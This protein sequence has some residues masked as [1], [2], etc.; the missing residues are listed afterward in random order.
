MASSRNA[1]TRQYDHDSW[2]WVMVAT[3]FTCCLVLYGN[4][5]A[6]GVLLIPMTND[7]ASDLWLVGWVAVLYDIMHNCMGPVVGALSRLL[8][9]RPMMVFGGLL[10]TLGFMLTSISSNVFAVAV[11]IVGLSG[12][13]T[14]FSTFISL[15]LTASYFK[16]KYPL[17]NGLSTMGGPI[18]MIAYG[19]VTQLLLGTYGWRGTMLLVGG[20]S[21]HLVA[22]AMLVRLDPSS[23]SPDNEQYQEVSVND[24]DENQS[25]GEVRDCTDD[26]TDNS[27]KCCCDPDHRQ[28]RTGM[29]C[30]NIVKAIDMALLTDVRFVLLTCARCTANF[31]YS[32]WVVYMVSHGQFQGLS[33][34]QASFLPTAF[35]VG[36]VIG[37][38]VLPLLQQ[39]GIKPSMTFWACFGAGIVSVS[40]LLDAFIRPFIGQLALTGFVGVGYGVFFQAL[41][42]MVRFLVS[43]HRFVSVLG[44]Q[45]MF[46]GVA[47]TLGGLISGWIYEWTGGF[48]IVLCVFAGV[49]LLSIPFFVTEALYAKRKAL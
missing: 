21:F 40:F 24:G 35:G 49:T 1:T 18:G 27:K 43:D 3:A 33:E 7:L 25:A 13:G 41:D 42:V 12:I 9:S 4:L 19:P 32:A 38:L 30:R 22:C 39:I 28:Y 17:A 37:K 47:G 46:V 34:I 2:G 29:C 14:A 16:D 45:G 10:T 20:I 31:T 48:S 8:G 6:L 5:K 15:A 26:K 44:W 11:F 23:S 36:N